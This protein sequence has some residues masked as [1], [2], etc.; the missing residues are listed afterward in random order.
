MVADPEIDARRDVAV[1]RIAEVSGDRDIHRP[2]LK[3]RDAAIGDAVVVEVFVAERDSCVLR[4][5]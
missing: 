3:R 2:A 4:R 5:A 1:V